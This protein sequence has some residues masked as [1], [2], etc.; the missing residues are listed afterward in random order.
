MVLVR[1]LG[2]FVEDALGIEHMPDSDYTGK[3]AVYQAQAWV[4]QSRT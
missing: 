4:G 1:F 3:F 2:L